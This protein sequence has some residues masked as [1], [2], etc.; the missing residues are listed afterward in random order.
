[1]NPYET[2]LNRMREPWRFATTAVCDTAEIAVL[3]FVSQGL[4]YTS[5]DVIALTAM[6]LRRVPE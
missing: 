5:A 1:M 3:W 4:A 6:I 2:R